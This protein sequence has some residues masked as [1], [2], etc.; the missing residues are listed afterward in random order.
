MEADVKKL[1]SNI[2]IVLKFVNIS[3][4]ILFVPLA[5]MLLYQMA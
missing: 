2:I 5:L 3:V 1:V 4:L